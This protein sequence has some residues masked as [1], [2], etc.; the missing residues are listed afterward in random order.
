MN[1]AK[2]TKQIKKVRRKS[3]KDT[4]IKKEV[5]QKAM[6]DKKNDS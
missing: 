5:L 2:I 3:G 6:K 1:E 4:R